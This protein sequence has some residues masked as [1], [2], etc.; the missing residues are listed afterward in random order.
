MN[1]QVLAAAGPIQP[2]T[3]AGQE[4]ISI[5][6]EVPGR[7]RVRMPLLGLARLDI[8]QLARML[9]AIP[10]VTAVRINPAATS[11]VFRH[12]GDA[13]TRARILDRLASLEH[14]Q[15][16]FQ[17]PQDAAGRP[18]LSPMLWRAAL[19]ALRPVL[20]PRL[21]NALTVAT[22]APRVLRGARSVLRDGVTIELLDAL[23]VSLGA[24]QGNFGTAL[25]T[26]TMMEAGEFLEETTIQRSG[27]LLQKLLMPNPETAMIER[28]GQIVEV[29]FAE[30]RRGDT[31]VVE[32][33]GLV[34]VDGRVISG[35]AQVNQASITGESLPET[36]EPGDAV[37]A[38]TVI[39]SGA[40]R[41]EAQFVGSET[42]T[43]RIAA[44][45]RE[46]LDKRS[47]TERL[48]ADL[49]DR[50][51]HMTLALGALTLLLTRDIRRVSSVFLIDYAC[52]TKLSAP[53]AVRATMS[54]A[55]ARG[56]L[57]KGGPIIEKLAKV[58]T[59]VFDKTGTLSH[60]TLSVTDV[61][62]LGRSRSEDRLLALASSLE[63][64][65]QH[66][67]ARAIVAEAR[68]RQLGT[69]LHG[70]VEQK[71]GYGL[72]AMVGKDEVLIGSRHYLEQIEGV[73]FSAHEEQLAAFDTAGKMVLFLARAGKPAG[74]IGLHD[75]LRE[76][77]AETVRRL[78]AEGVKRLVMLTGDRRARAEGFGATLGFD[79]V[80]AELRP[81]D[82]ARIIGRLQDEGCKI[83]FVGDGINDAPALAAAE[84]G[85]SM[86]QGAD[87]AQAAADITLLDDRLLAVAE[88]RTAA[89]RA[90][91]IIH[92]N[93][94]LGIAIN[95]GLFVA[96]SAGSL[97]PVAASVLHNG[98]T[99][100]L[101]L[102]A[103]AGAGAPE[104]ASADTST[105][106]LLD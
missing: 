4:K 74:L 33:G 51:V 2:V 16:C 43:A 91:R 25:T 52:A 1:M 64:H 14:G 47:E 82:K 69:V 20:P 36:K 56:I 62:P 40:L 66:P 98:S 9:R 50:Q 96:A 41:I 6:H 44:M 67:V 19:L 72:R 83:A 45:I 3:G 15:L 21:G 85:F 42:T 17:S 88:A 92:T 103:L 53:V 89:T 94:N 28:D 100:A 93:G 30:V 86:P 58:D 106:L 54:A 75:A 68:A 78:R 10:G 71:V 29:A 80:H 102:A 34:P 95:T 48:A 7:L 27:A 11:L 37:I 13:G 60:G 65:S 35:R 104:P 79:E 32:T 81:E 101:L 105:G 57:I 90:M 59:V 87:I 77:A 76:D 46:S 12:D 61:V 5:V 31:V 99:F 18:A 8:D 73:D 26:D 24:A 84:V 70:E 38:D 97:P 39:E 49:A 22:I 23:A 63:A 55:V